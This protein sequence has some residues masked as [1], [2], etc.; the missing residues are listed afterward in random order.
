MHFTVSFSRQ[1]YPRN[2]AGS[3]GTHL[4]AVSSTH[5]AEVQSLR[6]HPWG[7]IWSPGEAVEG[8]LPQKGGFPTECWTT[9]TWPVVSSR[10]LY[11]PAKNFPRMLYRSP[12]SASHDVSEALAV[13]DLASLSHLE[14]SFSLS[15]KLPYHW[16]VEILPACYH[17]WFLV[18]L[19]FTPYLFIVYGCMHNGGRLARHR[20]CL[21]RSGSACTLQLASAFIED[22]KQ[23]LN[24]G[25]SAL[26]E[27][28]CLLTG[29]A[30]PADS[31]LVSIPYSRLS[32]YSLCPRSGRNELFYVASVSLAE[33]TK[34]ASFQCPFS[35]QK[36]NN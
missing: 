33:I 25:L 22:W 13:L 1:H 10:Q 21:W 7:C 4:Q 12:C 15:F 24:S 3:D 20:K 34:R 35:G 28:L 30:G 11:F 29:L 16:P 9:L 31:W 6:H 32:V 18:L 26:Q 5:T 14:Q 8:T 19:F 27:A 36:V 17:D 23:S 2:L